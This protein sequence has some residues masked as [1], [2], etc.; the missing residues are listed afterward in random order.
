MEQSQMSKFCIELEGIT[1]FDAIK[2]VIEAWYDAQNMDIRIN[3]KAKNNVKE[4][5]QWEEELRLKVK[6][7]FGRGWS[8]YK[9]DGN[10]LNPYGKTRLTRIE[11]D[12]TPRTRESVVIPVEYRE[13]NAKLISSHVFEA[14]DLFNGTGGNLRNCIDTMEKLGTFAKSSAI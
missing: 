1:M 12:C 3:E 4:T 9:T 7:Q 5:A 6:R 10:K 13:E 14:I 11:S 2:A 8:I